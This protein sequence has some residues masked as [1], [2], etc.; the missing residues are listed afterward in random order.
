MKEFAQNL[1]QTLKIDVEVR[2]IS[3]D[4][5]G[6]VLEE[7]AN[8]VK[9]CGNQYDDFVLNVAGGDKTLTCAAVS[10]AFFNGLKAFHLMDESPVLLP[11]LK[12]KYNSVISDAKK[13]I[14]RTIMG[15]GGKVGNLG[16]L[17]DKSGYGKPLLSYHIWG[18]DESIGLVALGLVEA[19]RK[20]RGRLQ[21]EL[22]TLGRAMLL[23]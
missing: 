12:V 8:I 2:L 13:K 23:A 4:I 22:T 7:V 19:E 3:G 18:D 21:V 17:S 15:L 10:A 11:I 9:Q 20:R 5:V 1:K 6:G 16:D 14:L